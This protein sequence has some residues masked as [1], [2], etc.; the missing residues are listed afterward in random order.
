MLLTLETIGN[1]NPQLFRELKGRFNFR[2]IALVSAT[3]LLGQF[4][5]LR[6]DKINK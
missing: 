6:I 1:W 3:S 5:N 4:Q 2:N